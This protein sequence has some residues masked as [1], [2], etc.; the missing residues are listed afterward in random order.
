MKNVLIICTSNKTRS[1]LAMEIANSIAVRKNAP[2]R[3]KS[4]GFAIM[5]EYI[6]EN[7][8]A[9]LSEMGIETSYKPTH[10]S[11]YH[12][13]EFDEFHVMTERQKITLKSY[14]KNKNIDDKITVLGIDDPYFNGIEGYRKCRDEL[15][16]FYEDYIKE[17]SKANL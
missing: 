5:G 14:F 10:I 15:V 3:F 4:A 17:I 7:V 2:C 6:D 12:A 11:E 16:R 9:V 8:Q 13:D 1:P